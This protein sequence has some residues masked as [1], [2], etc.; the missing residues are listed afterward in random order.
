M[1]QLMLA[2]MIF[3]GISR[4]V[5][6]DH[7]VAITPRGINSQEGSPGVCL[8]PRDPVDSTS[9]IRALLGTSGRNIAVLGDTVVIIFPNPSGDAD[10]IFKGPSVYYSFDKG[11]TYQKFTLSDSV[12]RR[13]YSG[14]I[15][16][17]NWSSPLFFWNFARR[18]GGSYVPSPVFIAWDTPTVVKRT[19]GSPLPS[20]PTT[21]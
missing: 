10:N 2:L 4:G 21:Q 13:I 5:M 3:V 18:E 12:A 8:S 1:C 19:P 17:S 14:V 9:D 15:W 16:P 11:H 20:Q 6:I 7:D